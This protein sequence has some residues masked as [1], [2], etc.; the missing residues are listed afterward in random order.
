MCLVDACGYA[1]LHV[2]SGGE[3]WA[4]ERAAWER[5]EHVLKALASG[6]APLK[7]SSQCKC[8]WT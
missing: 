1:W 8:M 2:S 7:P 4:H 5:L 3:H 6:C